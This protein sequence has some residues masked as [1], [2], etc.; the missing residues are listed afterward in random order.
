MQCLWV[1]FLKTKSTNDVFPALIKVIHMIKREI[2]DRVV[3]VRADNSKGEFGL[4]FQTIYNKDGII[5]EPCPVYKHS[6]NR[7]SE[8]HLYITD[9]KARLLLFDA[10]LPKDF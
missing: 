3:I 4:K 10:D 1:R 9:C 6:I 2:A 8:R 7:V 5:F